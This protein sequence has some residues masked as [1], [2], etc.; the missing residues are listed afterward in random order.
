MRDTPAG[1]VEELR[2]IAR[3]EGFELE[4]DATEMTAW[5]AADYIERLTKALERIKAGE[6]NP[7]GI[8]REALDVHDW[9]LGTRTQP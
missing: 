2:E 8:A 6:A 7:V 9:V 4:T 3:F 5:D 1:I